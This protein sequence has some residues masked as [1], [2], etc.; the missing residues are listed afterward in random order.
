M[1]AGV[2]LQHYLPLRH[3]HPLSQ[4]DN[5]KDDVKALGAAVQGPEVLVEANL[6]RQVH[7]VLPEDVGRVG[8]KHVELA[9]V[10]VGPL[11]VS[12]D[13]QFN[14]LQPVAKQAKVLGVFGAQFS[15]QIRALQGRYAEVVALGEQGEADVAATRAHLEEVEAGGGLGQ[16]LQDNVH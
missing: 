1:V 11:C 12:V 16:S 10:V 2:H 7:Q 9:A 6:W 8:D 14:Y 3:Q 5:V 4:P 15:G 13:F